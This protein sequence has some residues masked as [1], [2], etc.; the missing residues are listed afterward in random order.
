VV[1]VCLALVSG[2]AVSYHSTSDDQLTQRL[3]ADSVEIV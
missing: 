2:H 3:T 1:G